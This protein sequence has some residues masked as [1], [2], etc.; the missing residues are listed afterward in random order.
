MVPVVNVDGY[1][2]VEDPLLKLHQ[3][4]LTNKTK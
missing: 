1:A 3:K 2:K 4:L